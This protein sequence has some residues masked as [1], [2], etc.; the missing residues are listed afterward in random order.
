LERK[1]RSTL[2]PPFK[3]NLRK[4]KHVKLRHKVFLRR[5]KLFIANCEQKLLK[6]YQHNLLPTGRKGRERTLVSKGNLMVLKGY[7]FLPNYSNLCF[8]ISTILKGKVEISKA[9][10]YTAPN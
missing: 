1:F 9:Y 5:T 8:K 6:E 7:L 4:H 2:K 10:M 3:L